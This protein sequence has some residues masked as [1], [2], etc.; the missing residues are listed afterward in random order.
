MGLDSTG[1]HKRPVASVF[2]D[3]TERSVFHK[4]L[5]NTWMAEQKGLSSVE[6]VV[7]MILIA[8]QPICLP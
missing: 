3:G 7:V 2:E 5:V 4:M 6:S 8:P 1:S